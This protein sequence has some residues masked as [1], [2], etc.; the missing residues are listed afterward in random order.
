MTFFYSILKENLSGL[1]KSFEDKEL[2]KA[3]HVLQ[4]LSDSWEYLGLD[5]K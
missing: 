3:L 5:V 1:F 4:S 2:D